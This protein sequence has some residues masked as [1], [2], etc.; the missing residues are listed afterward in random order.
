MTVHRPRWQ[1]RSS[2]LIGPLALS[3][4]ILVLAVSEL[5]LNRLKA[6]SDQRTA[7]VQMQLSVG[8]LRRTLLFMESAKRGYLLTGRADYLQ[9]YVEQ[10]AEFKLTLDEMTGLVDSAGDQRAR[11]STLVEL[12]Q[13]KHAE[14]SEMLRLHQSGQAPAA[15]NLMLTDA[16]QRMMFEISQIVDEVLRDEAMQQ[17]RSAEARD[18]VVLYSRMGIWLL[19]GLCVVGALTLMR[20][21]RDQERE[22]RVHLRQLLAERDRL[23]EEVNRRTAETVDL[24]RHMERVREDERARLARE[25][26]DELGGLLTTAKLDVARMRK[27]IVDETGTLQE[28]LTH[29]AESLDS[30][31]SLK[32]RI[33]EDLRPSSLSHLGLKRTLEIQC[34]EFSQRAELNVACDVDD[35]QL[36]PERSLAVYRLVQEALTNVAK[37][38]RARDIQVSLKRLGRVAELT[39]QDDGVGFDT[40]DAATRGGRGLEGMRFRIHASGGDVHI[41]S[42]P[43]EGT[44]IRAT[45]PLT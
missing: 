42:S 38:A 18:S 3:L 20:L 28:L 26:H 15:L 21:G 29:L 22:R 2:Q 11:L 13:R 8:R 41:Q 34:A 9:P 33:I 37:Y 27:R 7:S 12:S 43:G 4:A 32:R 5:G 45:V 40:L 36:T 19:V 25:L 1:F 39:V 30:G 16:G 35:L 23:D 44:F 6:V 31:I 14:M 17:S 10:E 24:A